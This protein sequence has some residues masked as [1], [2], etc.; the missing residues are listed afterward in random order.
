MGSADGSAVPTTRRRRPADYV[1]PLILISRFDLFPSRSAVLLP[2]PLSRLTRAAPCLLVVFFLETS[3]QDAVVRRDQRTRYP[4]S[5]LG[6]SLLGPRCNRPILVC[7]DVEIKYLRR[8]S[9]RVK[10]EEQC[11]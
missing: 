4:D 10:D 7:L 6:I 9:F 1:P 2:L 8:E 11:R 3:S 5:A